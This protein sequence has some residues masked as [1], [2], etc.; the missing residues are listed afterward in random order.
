MNAVNPSNP[1]N[2]ASA[3]PAEIG[4][5]TRPR[6]VNA[7]V[8]DRRV[9]LQWGTPEDDGGTPI[10]G[11]E[12]RRR[13]PNPTDDWE[14]IPGGGEARSH[15]VTGLNNGVFHGFYLRARNAESPSPQTNA[16]GTPYPGAPGAPPNFTVETY[17][18][19]QIKLSW[20]EPTAGSG[21]TITGAIT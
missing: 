18:G 21:V 16:A 1:S 4:P 7:S 8:G 3:T 13:F 15:T 2:E 17:S 9:I 19:R 12:L 14:T 5:P 6:P 10:T 20:N 11:Y